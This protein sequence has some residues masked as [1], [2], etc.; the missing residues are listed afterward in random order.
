MRQFY[1]S[2]SIAIIIILVVSFGVYANTLLNG[3][4]FDD[5]DQVLKNRWITGIRHIPDI[6]LSSVWS[7]SDDSS[8]FNY[9]RPI[10]HLIYMAEYHV[11]GL[12]PWGWHLVNIIFHSMNS[13]MVFLIAS[14]FINTAG[15]RGKEQE[16][17]VNPH[18]SHISHLTSPTIGNQLPA[19]MAAIIFATHPINTEAVAWV[20]CIP[21]LS[22][23]LFYMLSFYF[24]VKLNN[25]N[26]DK[27]TA[28]IGYYLLS[29][30]AFFPAILS[31][32]TGLTLLL[33]IVIYD[34]SRMGK[35]FIRNWRQYLPYI[36][37]IIIYVAVK[38]YMPKGTMTAES[39]SFPL[40]P[41][42]WFINIPP[43]FIQYM[44]K[45]LFPVNLTALYVWQTSFS[46]TEPKAF[47]SFLAVIVI[48]FL[49]FIFRKN[50]TVCISFGLILMPLLPVLYLPGLTTAFAERYLYLPSAGFAMLFSYMLQKLWYAYKPFNI[51]AVFI[52]LAA[53]VFYTTATI[54]RNPVW[55]DEYILW[56]D[57]ATKSP[58][59]PM[60]HYNLGLIYYDKGLVDE[61]IA[62]YKKALDLFTRP[63]DRKDAFTNIGN[64]YARKG[65]FEEA[66]KNYAN[67]LKIAPDDA[68]ILHNLKIAR[69]MLEQRRHQKLPKGEQEQ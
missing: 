41:Y 66:I 65:L 26:D 8:K 69:R 61:A 51:L 44:S 7:F 46:I 35:T 4:V 43:I 19:I 40:T 20:A 14:I 60:A 53:I 11:F 25:R 22:F 63:S 15:A 31:K 37:A 30:A 67:A 68:D 2:K 3:F 27:K 34:Y 58:Y 54:K 59:S 33:F 18:T 38:I 9:Y 32:E 49:L 52:S 1:N 62:S 42:Q 47:A 21:E 17:S 28:K 23:T 48:G 29:I 64:T 12:K 24:Y 5:T 45:L 10:M 6:F 50:Q 39:A 57:T 56:S 16:A 13:V 36:T 55:H